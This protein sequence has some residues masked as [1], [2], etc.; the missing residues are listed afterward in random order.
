MKEE[1]NLKGMNMKECCVF[2]KEIE[3]IICFPLS[4]EMQSTWQETVILQ[5]L[6]LSLQ[7]IYV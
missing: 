5:G 1:K 2:H 6:Q 3:T 4:L 7:E